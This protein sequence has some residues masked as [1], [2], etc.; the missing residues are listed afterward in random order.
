METAHSIFSTISVRTF[1]SSRCGNPPASSGSFSTI[2]SRVLSGDATGEPWSL[3]YL[4]AEGCSP[5][6]SSGGTISKSKQKKKKKKGFDASRRRMI[7]FLDDREIILVAD[8]HLFARVG[9]E[10]V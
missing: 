9:N 7:R 10:I 1:I 4:E 5:K 6:I 3:L 8:C 2:G